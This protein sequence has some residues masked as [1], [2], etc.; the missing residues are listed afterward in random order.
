M[1]AKA[2]TLIAA[3]ISSLMMHVASHATEVKFPSKPMTWLIPFSVGSGTDLTARVVAQEFTRLTGQ[4]VVIDNKPGANGTIATRVVASAPADGYTLLVTSNTHYAN[5]FLVKGLPYDPM[6]DFVPVA[7]V[8]EPSPLILVVGADSPYKTLKD[9]TD[10][11]KS[12]KQGMSYGSG[13]SSSRVAG[14]MYKQLTGADLLYVPYKGNTDAL[15]DVMAGRVD[16]IFSDVGAMKALYASGRIRPL[17]ILGNQKLP[18]LKDVPTSA[19]AG[20]PALELSSWGI[21][22]VRQGTPDNIISELN[23]LFAKV[24]ESDSIQRHIKSLDGI[25]TTKSL[26]ELD[27]FVK[28]QSQSWGTTIQKAGIQPQ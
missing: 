7:M 2:L 1:R 16:M 4:P 13:N 17:A 19:E 15:N 25:P 12:N 10:A 9:L 18:F 23:G 11:V 22:L 26:A 5:K 6:N 24:S 27:A 3:G 21:F 28:S 8:R 14:E 20:M